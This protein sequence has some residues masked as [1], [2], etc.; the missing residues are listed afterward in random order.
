MAKKKQK[1]VKKKRL[2][3]IEQRVIA[4]LRSVKRAIDAS[5]REVQAGRRL[6]AAAVAKGMTAKPGSPDHKNLPFN[7]DALRKADQLLEAFKKTKGIMAAECCMNT[8]N[9]NFLVLSTVLR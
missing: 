6:A 7:Q 2:K 1:A 5:A 9:C 8:E 3:T 4:D